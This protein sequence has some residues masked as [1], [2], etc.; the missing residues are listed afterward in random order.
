M[1][2]VLVVDDDVDLAE[3]IKLEVE[4]LLEEVTVDMAYNGRE[5]LQ[6]SKKEKYHLIITDFK[7]PEMNGVEFIT[8]MKTNQHNPNSDTPI[9]L[10]SAFIPDV[11]NILD[12]DGN[13]LLV[14]KPYD[15]EKFR[16]NIQGLVQR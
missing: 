1:H 5:S 15:P 13:I 16:K 12:L 2:R 6:L 9:I 3:T 8:A 11:K 14:D 4:L 7:M 10:I